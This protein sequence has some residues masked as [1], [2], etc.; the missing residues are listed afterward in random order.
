[1]MMMI[2]II[3]MIIIISSSS[4]SLIILYY[5]GIILAILTIRVPYRPIITGFNHSRATQKE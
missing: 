2:I 3:F 5:V 4:S 1:M